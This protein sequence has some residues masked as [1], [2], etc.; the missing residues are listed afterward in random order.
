[1]A[2]TWAGRRARKLTER[3]YA[4]FD[5]G[6]WRTEVLKVNQS[7]TST[8]TRTVFARV[9]TAYTGPSGDLG[10]TYAAD[11]Q[12]ELVDYDSE[13]FASAAEVFRAV[14]GDTRRAIGGR[15]FDAS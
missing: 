9:V 6:G 11:I 7:P 5:A 10:D 15:V 13:V 12:G 3:P 2:G 8:G 4:V 1:M 14:F